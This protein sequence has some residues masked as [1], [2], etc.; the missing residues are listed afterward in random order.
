MRTVD[1]IRRVGQSERLAVDLEFG[2]QPGAA[3]AHQ[4]AAPDTRQEVELLLVVQFQTIDA[5]II[6]VDGPD[7]FETRISR[8]VLGDGLDDITLDV[9]V[10]RANGE[11]AGFTDVVLDRQVDVARL[12]R[13]K[14]GIA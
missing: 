10:E 5:R 6:A 11:N 14:L 4:Q 9:L 12:V 7:H 8:I 13:V 3:E 2:I 1:A